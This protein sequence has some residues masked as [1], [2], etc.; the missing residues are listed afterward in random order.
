MS[1]VEKEVVETEE[2]VETDN[3][4]VSVKSEVEEK[5]RK[6]IEKKQQKNEAMGI[7]RIW[8]YL[9]TE[10]KWEN[11][12]F[13]VIS[14]ITLILGCLILTGSLVVKDNFPVIGD[15][16]TAFA[17]ILVVAA[18]LGL[19]YALYPFY[20]PAIPEFKKITWLTLPKFLGNTI[21]VFLFLIIFTLLFLLY[22]A[23][24]TEILRLIF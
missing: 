5:I 15:H 8:E 19:I 11:Y 22:D 21:R 17:I 1:E 12:F 10:H 2:V 3:K 20:K 4:D 14:L 18:G 23:F 24:I 6:Q 13:V 9:K 7:Y 16:P